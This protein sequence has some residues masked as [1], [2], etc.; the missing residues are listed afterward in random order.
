MLIGLAE[1]ARLDAWGDKKKHGVGKRDS[2]HNRG[3]TLGPFSALPDEG[4][5]LSSRIP[6]LL[7]LSLSSPSPALKSYLCTSRGS[8]L[9]LQPPGAPRSC[10]QAAFRPSPLLPPPSAIS[11]ST[12]LVAPLRPNQKPRFRPPRVLHT[13]PKDLGWL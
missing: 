2:G 9:R 8:F 3:S 5:G 11:A 1:P 13:L 10:H 4:R 12:A 6:G 7:N